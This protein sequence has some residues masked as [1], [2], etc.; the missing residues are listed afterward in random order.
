M[1]IKVCLQLPALRVTSRELHL[2]DLCFLLSPTAS[3]SWKHH[4][5]VTHC[6]RNTSFSL[7]HLVWS[8][9]SCST[10]F[11]SSA[12]RIHWFYWCSAAMWH[13]SKLNPMESLLPTLHCLIAALGHSV[14][15][16][17]AVVAVGAWTL[18]RSV[19]PAVC[20]CHLLRTKAYAKHCACNRHEL[21]IIP[22]P[23]GIAGGFTKYLPLLSKG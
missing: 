1:H 3:L 20:Y 15:A 8:L 13:F 21:C 14:A 11:I 2:G 12:L 10:A 7:L 22:L 9:L 19:L 16:W 18:G 5:L 17:E 23:L 4:S 6:N